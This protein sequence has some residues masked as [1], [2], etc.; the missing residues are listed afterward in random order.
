MGKE[1][2]SSILCIQDIIHIYLR[3]HIHVLLLEMR[4]VTSRE[5][6]KKHNLVSGRKAWTRWKQNSKAI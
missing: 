2:G 6:R 4:E 3:K 5:W 1:A